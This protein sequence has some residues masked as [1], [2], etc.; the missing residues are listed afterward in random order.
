DLHRLRPVLRMPNVKHIPLRNNFMK[1][2]EFR[3]IAKKDLSLKHDP[4]PSPVK[5]EML[6]E[7]LAAELLPGLHSFERGLS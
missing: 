5:H 3:H 6:G 7:L 2:V 1:L 4:H